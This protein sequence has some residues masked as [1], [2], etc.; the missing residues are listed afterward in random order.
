MTNWRKIIIYS[1]AKG[2]VTLIYKNCG[3]LHSDYLE[4]GVL[5]QLSVLFLKRPCHNYVV[6]IESSM[7]EFKRK[8][9]LPL[10]ELHLNVAVNS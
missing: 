10:F 4:L 6:H 5:K 1:T 7:W 9:T 3:G 2:L 8:H